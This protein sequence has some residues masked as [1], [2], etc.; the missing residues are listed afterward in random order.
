LAK[1][2]DTYLGFIDLKK[3]YDA[4]WREGLFKK[5]EQEGVYV[6]LVRLVRV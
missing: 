3:A 1:Q 2:K 4:V 5:M 6:K